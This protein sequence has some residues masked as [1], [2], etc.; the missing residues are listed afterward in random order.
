MSEFLLYRL[1]FPYGLHVAA[2]GFGEE[3]VR[4]TVASDTLFGAV[5]SAARLLHG[6]TGA[7]VL[8]A[9]DMVR[10]SSAFPFYG[11]TL[12]FPRPLSFAP[13]FTEA[14]TQ[15]AFKRVRF[16]AQPI[17]EALLRGEAPAFD[18]GD[19]RQGC[20][21]TAPLPADLWRETERPRVAVDR[22]TQASNLYHFAEVHFGAE[23]GL[24]FL[25]RFGSDA[26]E[27]R[28]SAAL[29]LLGD[30][31]LGADRTLGKGAFHLIGDDLLP[32]K[33]RPLPRLS[34]DVPEAP[35][36]AGLL[37]G[38]LSPTDAEV[39]SLDPHRSF[40]GLA[41][42]RGWV[43][44][45]GGMDLRRRSARMFAEGSVLAFAPPLLPR[46][47]TPEVLGR[48][49]FPSLPHPIYRYGQ[50]LALPIRLVATVP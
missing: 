37:L 2:P 3:S 24:F 18:G 14:A 15:K 4:T 23:V 34:V 8:L 50:G 33:D 29:R 41:T 22:V 27:H 20:W 9:P 49:E 45:P 12:F 42:R 32:L 35:E 38:L 19:V 43:T 5:C 36:S 25:A 48:E 46:G 10:L 26:A 40:Y 1:R 28:F 7:E 31:G 16:I 6:V 30:E 44:A 17:F 39:A 47:Q 21:A 11:E 13:E